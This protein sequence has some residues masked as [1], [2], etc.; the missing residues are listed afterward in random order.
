[1]C[2]SE[3]MSGKN[4]VAAAN[5]CDDDTEDH[6][7]DFVNLVRKTNQSFHPHRKVI[8]PGIYNYNNRSI[9]RLHKAQAFSH[10]SFMVFRQ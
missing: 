4:L 6:L 2:Y 9:L 7:D 3:A 5:M 10:L 1:M 8:S